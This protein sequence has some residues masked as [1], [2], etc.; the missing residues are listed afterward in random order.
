MSAE[1]TG[2]P[3]D[4]SGHCHPA[5]VPDAEAAGLAA[6]DLEA[7]TVVPDEAAAA[8]FSVAADPF[9]CVDEPV[10]EASVSLIEMSWSSWLSETIWLTI[11]V[12][13]TGCVGS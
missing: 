2:E 10:I 7:G 13:S 6:I 12:G 4:A 5:A 1:G 11:C 3:L 8:F 9:A